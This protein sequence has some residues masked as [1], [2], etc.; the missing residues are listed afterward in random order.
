M[1]CVSAPG[2]TSS[3]MRCILLPPPLPLPLVLAPSAGAGAA[4]AAAADRMARP[5]AAELDIYDIVLVNV[6]VSEKAGTAWGSGG[7]GGSSD[8]SSRLPEATAATSS[9]LTLQLLLVYKDCEGE[10]EADE[11]VIAWKVLGRDGFTR[12]AAV[13]HSV[14]STLPEAEPPGPALLALGLQPAAAALTQY[15]RCRLLT[16]VRDGAHAPRCREP[17]VMAPTQ[18][19]AVNS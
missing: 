10:A 11:A 6:G 16:D 2:P 14:L 13:A 17:A 12:A 7:A 4:V 15:V 5:A 18:V 1:S 9:C 19:R 3:R 8:P